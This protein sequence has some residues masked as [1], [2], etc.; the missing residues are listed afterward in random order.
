MR[1]FCQSLWQPYRP[2]KPSQ[3]ALPSSKCP[4]QL[5]CT[6][7]TLVC[8]SGRW[9]QPHLENQSGPH[10]PHESSAFPN[11]WLTSLIDAEHIGTRTAVQI[12]SHAQKF[13]SK[14]QR[15]QS[16]NGGS[17]AERMFNNCILITNMR[18]QIAKIHIYQIKS[19]KRK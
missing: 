11:K 5:G 18:F 3:N 2:S 8:Q 19:E 14:L 15:E 13:F 7:L 16:M 17:E 9:G 4:V 10:L 1:A 6:F 12:R